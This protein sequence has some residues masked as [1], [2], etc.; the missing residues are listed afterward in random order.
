MRRIQAGQCEDEDILVIDSGGGKE[1]E[2]WGCEL[3]CGGV[4]MSVVAA[5]WSRSSKASTSADWATSGPEMEDARL[6]R[7]RLSSATAASFTSAS[8]PPSFPHSTPIP[9]YTPS[10]SLLPSTTILSF[11]YPLPIQSATSFQFYVPSNPGL[12]IPHYLL[13]I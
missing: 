7:L 8:S 5:E 9:T 11:Q 3:G 1:R 12:S 6:R 2:S 10:F 4:E 13:P